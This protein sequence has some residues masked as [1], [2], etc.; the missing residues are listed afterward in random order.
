MN[1][2]SAG[3]YIQV[4]HFLKKPQ[5]RNKSNRY[6]ARL[7]VGRKRS[8]THLHSLIPLVCRTCT[9]THTR[10]GCLW[11]CIVN[12]MWWYRPG[13]WW[14]NCRQSGQVINFVCCFKKRFTFELGGL[15]LLLSL[16]Q[17]KQLSTQFY[18][19][20]LRKFQK[21]FSGV[22]FDDFTRDRR[23]GNVN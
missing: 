17:S 5:N 16:L 13:M 14:R 1:S 9:H 10:R 2:D 12:R 11:V 7:I 22:N 3:I 19:K 6:R 23:G 21:N 20:I 8:F 4:G 18:K 15:S